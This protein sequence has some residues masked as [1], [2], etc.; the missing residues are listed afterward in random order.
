MERR[1]GVCPARETHGTAGTPEVCRPSRCECPPAAQGPAVVAPLPGA[2]AGAD[3][4]AGAGAVG[5]AEGAAD[6]WSDGVAD[7]CPAGG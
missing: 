6:G 7:G 4:G 5:A 3:V 1:R 2:A